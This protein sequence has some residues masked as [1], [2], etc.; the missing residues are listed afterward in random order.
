MQALSHFIEMRGIV[1]LARFAPREL[2]LLAII[3]IVVYWR[4]NFAAKRTIVSLVDFK[5]ASFDDLE[6]RQPDR[7][8]GGCVP[9]KAPERLGGR[10]A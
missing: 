5:S 10:M 2:F 6:P 4:E 3:V 8:Y 9:S 7:F 1:M